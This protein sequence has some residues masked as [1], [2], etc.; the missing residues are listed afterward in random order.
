MD[1]S[2]GYSAVFYA[3]LL[4]KKT[5]KD[6]K[7]IELKEGTIKRALTDLRQS[8]DLTCD[9][10][11]T[12]QEEYIRVWF[13]AYQGG[14]VSHTP[15]FTGV[16]TSPKDKY[17]GRRR[18]NKLE[19]Y[20]ILKL[21]DDVLLPMGWYAPYDADAT[22][23]IRDLLSI[24]GLPITIVGNMTDEQKRLKQAIVSELN[25]NRLSMTDKILDAMNW[26]LRLD[27]FGS[28][29]VGPVD[30]A[31]RLRID[32]LS[33]DIIEADVDITY[34]WYSAPNI[35]RCVLDTNY[36]E[37]RDEDPNSPLSIQNRGRE[38]WYEEDNVTLGTGET[39]GEY[40]FRLLKKLQQISL[41]ISYSRRYHPDV[42][43]GDCIS[44]NYP[45]QSISGNFLVT[46][47]NI[48]LGGNAKVSEEVIRL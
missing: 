28:V 21:A 32:S 43:P 14:N 30:T 5:M 41:D 46:D 45:A 15:L 39:L 11:T 36:A 20:S 19:C 8:A 6:I 44:I 13:D 34:D 1:W 37:A 24:L 7:R 26:V 48:T 22:L 23:L 33:N 38:V 35:V 42:Y 31:P 4:D 16:A 17:S 25:E 12:K 47:Q 27:G 29:T 2:K 18:T 40:S 3:T 9:G 10:Y